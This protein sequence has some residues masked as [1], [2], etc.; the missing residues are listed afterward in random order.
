MKKIIYYLALALATGI[1]FA[2]CGGGDGGGSSGGSGTVSM[3]V[4]DAKPVLPTTAVVESVTIT[5]DEV[6]VH[7]SGGGWTTFSFPQQVKY[8]KIDLYQFSDGTKTQFVPPVKIDSGKYTQIRIGVTSAEIKIQGENDPLVLEIP[9]E[10]LKTDKN[11]EFDVPD[12]G[13]VDLTVD[14]DLS[15]SIVVTGTDTYQ[16]KP[17]LHIN[18]TSNAATITGTIDWGSASQATV[19]VTLDKYPYWDCPPSPDPNPGP[20]DEEYTKITVMRDPVTPT[21]NT[22]AI[23]WLVPGQGYFVKV[24]SLDGTKKY[25]VCPT[26][27]GPG[28]T[29]NLT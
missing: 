17:V 4:T 13:A 3:N 2:G 7:K 5:F 28:A 8:Y 18:K 20:E 26:D 12:G 10:N 25:Y 19:T 6:S 24:E 15:Q 11:F 1:I 14:F 23:F 9:S 16:L 27:L 21:S 29:F 22:F